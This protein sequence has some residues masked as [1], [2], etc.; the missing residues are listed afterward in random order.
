MP[1]Q[2]EA[3]LNSLPAKVKNPST[4]R[5]DDSLPSSQQS[6][7]F[8]KDSGCD[9]SRKLHPLFSLEWRTGGRG[10]YYNSHLYNATQFT[11]RLH[12]H[13]TPLSSGSEGGIHSFIKHLLRLTTSYW[14]LGLASHQ[15]KGGALAP[16][17]R[18]LGSS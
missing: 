1:S 17:S 8:T 15:G 2:R 11:K 3:L 9:F 10:M 7:S 14:P 4:L 13:Q 16:R 18:C 6:A 5:E 12:F